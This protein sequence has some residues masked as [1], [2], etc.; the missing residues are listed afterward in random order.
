[1]R[2]KRTFKI[3]CAKRK[4]V[5]AKLKLPLLM[6]LG[7]D[8]IEYKSLKSTDQTPKNPQWPKIKVYNLSLILLYNRKTKG[9]NNKRIGM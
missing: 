4:Y 5:C 2:E 8:F 9:S 7:L 3:I 1:V 6:N